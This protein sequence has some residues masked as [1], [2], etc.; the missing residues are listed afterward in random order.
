MKRQMKHPF[1][2][3]ILLIAIGGFCGLTTVYAAQDDTVRV[4]A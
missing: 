3:L 2:K 1:I 4:Q